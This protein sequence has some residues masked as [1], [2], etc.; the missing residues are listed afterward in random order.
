VIGWVPVSPGLAPG[1]AQTCAE[2]VEA[3]LTHMGH[4]D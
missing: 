3:G 1:I 2:P 4:T